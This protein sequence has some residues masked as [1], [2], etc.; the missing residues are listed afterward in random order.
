MPTYTFKINTLLLILLI[1]WD[2]SENL[3]ISQQL[4]V[5]NSKA[6]PAHFTHV[7]LFVTTI[8]VNSGPFKSGNILDLIF[9]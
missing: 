9:P 6:V 3:F 8:T 5:Y 1:L 7:E 2:L 4:F